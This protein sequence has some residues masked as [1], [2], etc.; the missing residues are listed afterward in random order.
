MVIKNQ[1][2]INL[3]VHGLRAEFNKTFEED[4]L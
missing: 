1:T 2:K 3:G 4:L